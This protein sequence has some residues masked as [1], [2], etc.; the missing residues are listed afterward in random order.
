VSAGEPRAA[1]RQ[2]QRLSCSAMAADRTQP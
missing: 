1:V 2:P